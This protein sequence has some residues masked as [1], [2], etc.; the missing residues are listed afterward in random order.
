MVTVSEERESDIREDKVLCKE[1]NE[2]KGFFGSPPGLDRE[3]DVSIIRL[4]DPTKQHCNNSWG[5]K[6]NLLFAY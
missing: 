6:I 1:V 5:K 3:I 4:H 2:F